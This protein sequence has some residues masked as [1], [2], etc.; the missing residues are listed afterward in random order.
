VHGELGQ[1]LGPLHLHVQRPFPRRLD[2]TLPTTQTAYVYVAVSLGDVFGTSI[3]WTEHGADISF[4]SWSNGSCSF[5]PAIV[6]QPPNTDW[7]DAFI[8][9][10]RVQAQAIS[11][12]TSKKS[13]TWGYTF[14]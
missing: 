4:G 9:I 2:A 7:G 3:L 14:P 11:G 10:V 13:T 5:Q 6:D 12:G 1:R 8:D